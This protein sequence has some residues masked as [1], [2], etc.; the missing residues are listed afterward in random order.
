MQVEEHHNYTVLC[1]H[2]ASDRVKKD[3]FY[4]GRRFAKGD[5]AV[6]MSDLNP[7]LGSNNILLGHVI[8]KHGLGDYNDNGWRFSATSTASLLVAHSSSTEPA[9]EFQRTNTVRAT[10]S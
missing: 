3:V 6:V 9:V 2:G 7:K 8:R 10:R 5:I 4:E 1:T